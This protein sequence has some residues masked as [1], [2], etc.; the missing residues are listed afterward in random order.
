MITNCYVFL[1]LLQCIRLRFLPSF[2]FLSLSNC[3]FVSSM[4]RECRVGYH[5]SLRDSLWIF[6]IILDLAPTVHIY[7]IFIYIHTYTY[8][9]AMFEYYF[10]FMHVICCRESFVS[11]LNLIYFDSYVSIWQDFL[12]CFADVKPDYMCIYMIVF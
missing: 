10:I 12:T 8:A 7:Q 11:F 9:F 5:L 3:R 6:F 4:Y 2:S 1:Q